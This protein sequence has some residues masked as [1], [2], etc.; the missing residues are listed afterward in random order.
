MLPVAAGD[1]PHRSEGGKY[2]GTYQIATQT[3]NLNHVGVGDMFYNGFRGS[4]ISRTWG[5][6]ALGDENMEPIVTRGIVLDIVGLKV[7]QGA[8]RDYFTAA[9]G[10][11]V[12]RDNYRVTVEDIQEAMRRAGIRIGEGY[13]T[14]ALVEDGV[15][16]FVLLL[17]PQYAMGSTAGN[18]PPAALGQP[19]PRP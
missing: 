13:V 7:S 12:L 3:D 4:E 2:P 9:N 16:E 18:T 10:S 1:G 14:D 11:P 6:T 19:R 8:T 5:T 17:T 15:F